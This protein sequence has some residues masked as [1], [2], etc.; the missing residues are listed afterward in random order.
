M[1]KQCCV[2]TQLSI[3]TQTFQHLCQYLMCGNTSH[4]QKWTF[5]HS[6]SPSSLI[7]T[8]CTFHC[9][10]QQLSLESKL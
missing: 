1:Q 4:I 7:S 2:K 9:A 8:N 3:N 6:G 5:P 10:K